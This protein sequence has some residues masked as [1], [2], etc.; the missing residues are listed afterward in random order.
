MFDLWLDDKH[1]NGY[2][3]NEL[4]KSMYNVDNLLLPKDK[5]L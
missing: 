3:I 4:M 5:C 2:Q 1:K